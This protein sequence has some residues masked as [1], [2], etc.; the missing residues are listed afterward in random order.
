[1]K[2]G[3]SVQFQAVTMIELFTDHIEIHTVQSAWGDLVANQIEL[4]QP[5][6]TLSTT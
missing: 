3:K 6:N 1:M 5:V 4:Y 2:P